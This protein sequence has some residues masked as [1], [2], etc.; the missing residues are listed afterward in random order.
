[1]SIGD[2]PASLLQTY[3]KDIHSFHEMSEKIKRLNKSFNISYAF[4]YDD[5]KPFLETPSKTI[6]KSNTVE[7]HI[8]ATSVSV[9][10]RFIKF[11]KGPFMLFINGD[12]VICHHK[13]GKSYN[14]RINLNASNYNN[15]LRYI[16]SHKDALFFV[17]ITIEKDKITVLDVR[18]IIKSR[19]FL[20]CFH[21]L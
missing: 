3:Q 5:L 8:N 6:K 4:S 2:I 16:S 7:I 14:A 19:P 18:T 9:L 21:L 10:G 13:S 15:L 1:M 20:Y 17:K 11:V 12:N